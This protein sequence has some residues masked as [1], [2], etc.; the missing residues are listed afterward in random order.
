MR[1]CWSTRGVSPPTIASCWRSRSSTCTGSATACIAGCCRGVARACSNASTMPRPQR[2]LRD[3]RP[4]VFFGVPTMYVRLLEVEKAAAREIGG[5]VQALRLGIGAASGAG[6]GGLRGALRSPHPR[7]LRHDRDVDDA[8]QPIRRRAARGDRR[9]PL[10]RRLH[11]HRRRAGTG[12]CATTKA[13][14]SSSSRRWCAPVTGIA[15][16]PLPRRLRMAGSG[17]AT[18]PSV[19][20]TAT[21][22]SAGGAATS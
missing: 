19:H 6:A 3:F 1:G 13:A 20:P 14:S 9:S 7:A 5:H 8:R 10:P 4:T 18:S 22:R 17:P 2:R 21:S 15:P 16:T 12:G 11:P